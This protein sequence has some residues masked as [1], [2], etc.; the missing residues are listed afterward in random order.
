[1]RAERQPRVRYLRRTWNPRSR[2]KAQCTRT[3]TLA[4]GAQAAERTPT[5]PPLTHMI[6]DRPKNGSG[7]PTWSKIVPPWWC[8]SSLP[9]PP[10]ATVRV[11]HRRPFHCLC[12]SRHTHR[13]APAVCERRV[14]AKLELRSC[15]SVIVATVLY[16]ELRPRRARQRAGPQ[17]PHAPLGRVCR[18]LSFVC[19]CSC[20][21]LSPESEKKAVPTKSACTRDRVKG[22]SILIPVLCYTRVCRTCDTTRT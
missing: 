2:A 3:I 1:M 21:E 13:T 8:H 5:P 22:L 11:R 9:R 20:S 17:D 15:A 7:T 4:H 6:E 18:T 10:G 14:S 16:S 12:L 19:V